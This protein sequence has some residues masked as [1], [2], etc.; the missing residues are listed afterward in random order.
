MVATIL[1]TIQLFHNFL[2]TE[3]DLIFYIT[4]S[5]YNFEKFKRLKLQ[6]RTILVYFGKL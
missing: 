1:N 6:K 5:R 3:Y 4:L 2:S